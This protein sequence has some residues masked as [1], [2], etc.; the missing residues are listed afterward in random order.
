MASNSVSSNRRVVITGVGAV[1][2]VGHDMPTTWRNL[3]DGQSGVD[4]IQRFDP[5]HWGVKVP[6]AAEVKD[7]DPEPLLP[8]AKALRHMDLN[9]QYGMVAG[10]EALNDSGL[11]V[12]EDN[13]HRIGIIF[14]S[15]GGG[16][17]LVTRWQDTLVG[18]GARRVSPFAMPNLIAD[19]ASGHLSIA[20]G[21]TG[22]NYSPTS[23]CATGANAV[24]DG[25][26]HIRSGRADALLVGGS[27]A[28]ILPLFHICFERMGVLATPVEP[29]SASCAPYDLHRNGFV[30]GEGAAAMMIEDLD[31]ALARR[32]PIYAEVVGGGSANDAHDIAQPEP[33][34]RGLMVSVHQAL[35]EAQIDPSCIGYVSTHGTATK[36]GDQVEV[37]ALKRMFGAHA[38][39]LAL[40][41]IKPA[42]GHMMGASGALEVI[43]S[44][45]VLKDGVA[46]P[47]LNYQTPDPE[48]DLDVIP[49]E[50][51]E[52]SIDAA[53]SFSV[54]LGGHNAAVLLKRFEE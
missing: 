37:T 25:M 44:A 43:V 46:P 11:E 19:A 17:E 47:T 13:H 7:W 4:R 50:A 1:T 48:L 18:R 33:H 15:G 5:D 39:D 2:P 22:P 32:A 23:A 6:L 51:R 20:T 8:D 45:M 10:L 27:E 40:S 9:T 16:M 35:D 28:I 34:G 12:T 29:L 31:H 36:L 41:S 52:L 21:A 42:T 26:L 14:G 54:G 49:N 3:V 24:A 53:L 30:P 38:D